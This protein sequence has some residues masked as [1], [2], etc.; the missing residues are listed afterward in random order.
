MK[1][2]IED[3]AEAYYKAKVDLWYSNDPRINDLADYEED[4]AGNLK[5]LRRRLNAA[6]QNHD[7]IEAK[8]LLEPGFIG[9]ATLIAKELI[10][11]GGNDISA[12]S[13]PWDVWTK[14]DSKRS[15]TASFRVLSQCSIDLHIL[16]TLW[17][18]DV[19]VSIDQALG[20]AS[21]ANGKAPSGTQIASA[22]GN[23]LRRAR[24]GEYNQAAPGS[25]KP[26]LHQYEQWQ[27][28]GYQAIELALERGE[29]VIALTADV[30]SFFPSLTADFLLTPEFQ[31]LAGIPTE[32][33]G[34]HKLFVKLMGAWRCATAESLGLPEHDIGIPIGLASS[35]IVGNAALLEFDSI[36]REH[37]NPLFY[38]RYVDDITLVFQN[39]GGFSNAREVIRW[40]M[41]RCNA[42][43]RP[44]HAFRFHYDHEREEHRV[45]YSRPYLSGSSI[46]FTDK[47]SKV[48]FFSGRSG[49][50]LLAALKR[51][52][53]ERASEWRELPELPEDATKVG[54]ELISFTDT[55]GLAA[56]TLRSVA[57]PTANRAQ[58]ALKL[59]N[60]EAFA[61]DL[62][63][64]S[65]KEHRREFFNAVNEFICAPQLF[66]S[67][68][69]YLPR[70]VAVA[71]ECHDWDE[72]TRLASSI[73]LMI[74]TLLSSA[75]V[76]VSI[77]GR[78]SSPGAIEQWGAHI[79]DLLLS[80]I[81]RSQSD[82]LTEDKARNL[83]DVLE[84][85]PRTSARTAPQAPQPDLALLMDAKG[86]AAQ[87]RKVF[88]SDL[89][90]LPLRVIALP[91]SWTRDAPSAHN[92]DA[93][94][95]LKSTLKRQLKAANRR[96][97]AFDTLGRRTSED[98]FPS[99][100]GAAF[101]TRPASLAEMFGATRA[102]SSPKGPHV[103]RAIQAIA[104]LRGYSIDGTSKPSVT[105]EFSGTS[106]LIRTSGKRSDNKASTQPASSLDI[107]LGLLSTSRDQLTKAIHGTPDLSRERYA[108]MIDL[109]NHV[110]R[111]RGKVKYLVLPE[112]SM[113][114][115]WFHRIANKLRAIGV[116]LISGIEYQ[117]SG[118]AQDALC[119]QAWASL[120]H[121]EW[122][123]PGSIVYAQDKLRPAHG[124]EQNL[125]AE[126][127]KTLSPEMKWDPIQIIDH[128]GFRFSILICS[129]LTNIQYRAAA[130]GLVDA[131]FVPEWNQDT[132]TFSSIV[133]AS[134][135]DVHCFVIQANNRDHGDSRI[136]GPL[137][138]RFTRD[139]VRV[140]GG[141]QD[142]V[143][144]GR[145]PVAKLREFQSRRAPLGI[146][147]F[148]PLPDGYSIHESRNHWER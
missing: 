16:T 139:I 58:F 110:V 147:H 31:T 112:L 17:I 47:K 121:T 124:E 119:N 109:V 122:G 77:N 10:L 15:A 69:R 67:F 97:K 22:Y 79:R 48:H 103:E 23:R 60:V 143:I 120:S 131:L 115:P 29:S 74:N 148:K 80:V 73:K 127:G 72:V 76:T 107:A 65:W 130:R 1:Y 114:A 85:F 66:F 14:P 92:I 33:I 50:T 6:L 113:P 134:A 98:P 44:K 21:T 3:L 108:T 68:E 94:T 25:L 88:L 5:K 63:P 24:G 19:G 138:Q 51:S 38:G 126:A 42:T 87:F 106:T 13:S 96:L 71:L 117:A 53:Q 20:P 105:P 101:P 133:E 142:S 61:R 95:A 34:L 137:K 99:F 26:Y 144:V 129:E 123:F 27:S 59:R 4:L 86:R 116:S 8:R 81:L 125:L 89:A 36:I 54:Q 41:N 84:K 18:R 35:G 82:S 39:S 45:N 40:L 62:A 64:D 32:H 12:H 55:N 93:N 9:S 128:Q 135:F 43:S 78:T 28:G 2:S 104:A 37:V 52:D 90:I 141:V 136:R 30:K 46:A 56:N 49:G 145:I 118:T 11:N 132:E 83:H 57:T 140:S 75:S 91:S 146:Q 100:P 102:L 7:S 111:A 70:I